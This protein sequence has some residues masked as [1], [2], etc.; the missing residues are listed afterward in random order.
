L[1]QRDSCVILCL[2]S[3][4]LVFAY[5]Q[6]SQMQ[7]ITPFTFAWELCAEPSI[8]TDNQEQQHAANKRTVRIATTSLRYNQIPSLTYDPTT[9]RDL[10]RTP[11]T[12]SLQSFSALPYTHHGWQTNLTDH[13][14]F[15][16]MGDD[17]DIGGKKRNSFLWSKY[18]SSFTV[19]KFVTCKIWQNW[20]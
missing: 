13:F 5:N 6:K 4:Y 15:H 19:Q 16:V 17:I 12:V 14:L 18:E 2:K 3:G 7:P 11:A 8:R 10:R 9:V 20:A 1:S